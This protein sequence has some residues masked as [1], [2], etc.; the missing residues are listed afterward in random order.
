MH[1]YRRSVLTAGFA[2]F[3][4][5]FGSGN[6]VFP[7]LTGQLTSDQSSWS[8]FGFIITA[9]VVP[10]LGLMG[11]ILY[12]GNYTRY[13][14]RLGKIPSAVLIFI[15]LA[16]IGPFGVVPRCVTVAYGGISLLAPRFSYAAFSL[17]FCFLIMG[18]IWSRN[19][20]VDV[21]GLVLTPFKLGGIALMMGVGL[22]YGEP[23]LPGALS[24][25]PAF[26]EGFFLG[27][28][29]M[30][31]MA[32]F[33]FSSTT[34]YYLRHQLKHEENPEKTLIRLSVISSLIGAGLLSLAYIGFVQLGA[35]YA[36]ILQSVKPEEMVVQIAFNS[37]GVLAL[38]VIAVTMAVACL[39]TA[40]ILCSVFVD[41]LQDHIT[42]NKIN[43]SYLVISTVS[44]AF[45]M[46]LLGFSTICQWLGLVLTVA[47][48][49]LIALS[50]VNVIK[51]DQS[52]KGAVP[53]W[54]VLGFSLTNQLL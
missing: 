4:M 44:I 17:I 7:L 9:V 45:A 25:W 23:A 15:M 14:S 6:L 2:M 24:S 42:K 11:M 46:S 39:A 22:W 12:D 30:D 47:Y 1:T 3:S 54:V 27:Y 31:L 29:T 43:H 38:P 48:P 51:P 16:L 18:L 13:F 34:V 20:V 5:F 26:K 19:R 8:T 40:V 35:K 21:I 36:P 32:G 53:F 28:Q 41:Y 10:F 52:W 33:F 37:L 49:A 50:I